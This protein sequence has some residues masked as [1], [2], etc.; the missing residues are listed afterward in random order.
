M[1]ASDQEIKSNWTME[2][3][4]IS[5]M[6]LEYQYFACPTREHHPKTFKSETNASFQE[7]ELKGERKS[8]VTTW[9]CWVSFP[10]SFCPENIWGSFLQ[11]LLS[12][13]LTTGQT[14][15]KNRL[16]VSQMWI[17]YRMRENSPL[18]NF[19]CL[20]D[21]ERLCSLTSLYLYKLHYTA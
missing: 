1:C 12:N 6:T 21:G 5:G 8:P 20:S 3:T 10:S 2:G 19:L 18:P 17:L 14:R 16:D 7:E 11:C 15:V 9:C 13:P 4:I